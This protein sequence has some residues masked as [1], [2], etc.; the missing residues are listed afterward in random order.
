MTKVSVIVPVYNAEN[1]LK[2]CVDSI[3]KS[4]LKDIELIL[5]NDGSTDNSPKTCDN[6]T[7]K[8]KRVIVIHQEN[9]RQAHA[10]NQGLKIAKGEYISF[11]DSDDYIDSTFLEKLYN[12]AKKSNS[13]IAVSNV[14]T[15]PSSV[16]NYVSYWSFYIKKTE[17]INPE[18]KQG[19]IYSCA[20]WNKIYKTSF[21]K[22]YNLYFNEKIFLEDVTFNQITTIL[23]NKICLEPQA[24]YFY[25]CMN[26]S[27][28]M[29]LA[30]KSERVLQMLQMTQETK[31]ALKEH[32]D[33]TYF[34]ILDDFEI[35]NLWGWFCS[36]ENKN[37][38]QEFFTRM[39]KIFEGIN[40]NNNP[41][42]DSKN[43][44]KYETVLYPQKSIK[45]YFKYKILS[46]VT[47]GKKRKMYK[48]KTKN[49]KSLLNEIDEFLDEY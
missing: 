28:F 38:K 40:I 46:K 36:I 3:L 45:K 31:F 12:A 41:F 32:C 26:N 10:R 43:K 15:I 27:S 42:I 49:I 8:D 7:K 44:R 9:K 47:F 1:W 13:D 18:E 25:N 16:F 35:Y 33:D 48:N 29:H 14:A 17:L 11:I 4:T 2:N 5:I 30:H 23:S 24:V 21:L 37:Y 39:K 20:I 19:V 22:K 6:Y 34:F